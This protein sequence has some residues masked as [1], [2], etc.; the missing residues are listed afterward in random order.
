MDDDAQMVAIDKDQL[1]R[2][3]G[4]YGPEKD[5][6]GDLDFDWLDDGWLTLL[7]RWLNDAQRA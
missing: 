7:R 6:C 2:M 4:E 1:A 3:R 5:G